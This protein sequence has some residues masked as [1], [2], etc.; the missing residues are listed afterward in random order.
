MHNS[1]NI[2]PELKYSGFWM[3]IWTEERGELLCLENVFFVIPFLFHYFSD[4]SEN[5]MI[6]NRKRT[7]NMLYPCLNFTLKGMEVSIFPIISLTP[8]F[9]YTLLIVEQNLRGAP[10]LEKWQSGVCDWRC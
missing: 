5:S 6:R 8:L 2:L 9:L 3:R 7:E 10:Y 1:L 4:V